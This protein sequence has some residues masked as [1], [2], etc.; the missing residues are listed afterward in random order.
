MAT[1]ALL[2]GFLSILLFDF[3]QS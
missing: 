3:Y 1:F 2:A